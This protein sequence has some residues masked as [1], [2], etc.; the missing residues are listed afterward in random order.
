ETLP[1]ERYRPEPPPAAAAEMLPQERYR[2][3]PPPV[4]AAET[5][6][7]E[8]YLPEANTDERQPEPV[9]AAPARQP[10]KMEPIALPPDMVMIETQSDKAARMLEEERQDAP[11][12]A[13]PARQRSTETVIPEEPLQ[14]VETR[15]E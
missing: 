5:L 6:P 4:V 2:P 14:Q 7:Q 12:P 13:R 3:E 8:R 11:Q 15:K 1:Q 9:A 10:W